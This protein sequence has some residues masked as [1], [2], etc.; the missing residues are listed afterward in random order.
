MPTTRA[1]SARLQARQPAQSNCT[2]HEDITAIKARQAQQVQRDELKPQLMRNVSSPVCMTTSAGHQSS[3]VH[4]PQ[5]DGGSKRPVTRANSLRRSCSSFSSSR[6]SVLGS[7]HVS[8]SEPSDDE[9]DLLGRD[10]LGGCS[11][12]SQTSTEPDDSNKE[13]VA[14]FR[15][16]SEDV[17]M[18]EA[19]DAQEESIARRARASRRSSLMERR[20]STC[21]SSSSS[22][23]TSCSLT[24]RLERQSL[25]RSS[26]QSDTR[27]VI[28]SSSCKY[29]WISVGVCWMDLGLQR[30]RKLHSAS[31]SGGMPY[32]LP[33]ER[34]SCIVLCIAS[35]DRIVLCGSAAL[36]C[37]ALLRAARVDSICPSSL[38]S[39]HAARPVQTRS[40][41]KGE[42]K[43][44]REGE[45]RR[46]AERAKEQ[47]DACRPVSS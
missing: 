30:P 8:D 43:G 18:V 12:Q 17:L 14:P 45:G 34:A 22:T 4:Q 13:N 19:R 24:A 29:H 39:S 36:L 5:P 26:S 42:T 44:M 20:T 40:E 23:A 3:Q 41:K 25:H 7:D 1:L 16:A 38:A 47:H 21:S 9:L 46:G 32:E 15:C 10:R 37:S 35:S 27:S 33:W 2:S 28:S 31:P 11:Q 6:R